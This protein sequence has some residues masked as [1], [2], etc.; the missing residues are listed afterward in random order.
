MSNVDADRP[1]RRGVTRSDPYGIRIK[2]AKA[3]ESDSVEDVA[4]V[5]KDNEPKVLF[6]HIKRNAEFRIEDD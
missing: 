4:A 2:R 3:A 1:H 5:V 6:H